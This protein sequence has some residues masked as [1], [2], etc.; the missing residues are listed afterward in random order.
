MSLKIAT[1]IALACVALSVLFFF[2]SFLGVTVNTVYGLTVFSFIRDAGLLL[3][4]VVFYL[5][6]KSKE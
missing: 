5:Q 2:F 3:F 6:Q 4:F 1:I